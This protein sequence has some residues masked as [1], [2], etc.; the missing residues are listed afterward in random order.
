MEQI[1][2]NKTM[3]KEEQKQH[4]IDMMKDDENLKLYENW[5][6]DAEKESSLSDLNSKANIFWSGFRVGVKS[7]QETLDEAAENKYGLSD[8]YWKDRIGFVHG[9]KWQS[10]RMY[11]E[12]DMEEAFENGLKRSFDSDFDRWFE[13][14]KKK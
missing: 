11:S 8:Q 5:V 1:F 2:K 6:E 9:A 4:L 13:Q 12:E 3:K 7:K 14:F 10:E